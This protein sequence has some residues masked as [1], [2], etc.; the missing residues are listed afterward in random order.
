[1][2]LSNKS[3]GFSLVEVLI[4]LVILSVSLLALAG[5]MVQTTHN[6]S[7]GNHMTEAS[8]VAQDIFERLR[9]RPYNSM[10]CGPSDYVYGSSGQRYKRDCAMVKTTDDTQAQARITVTWSDPTNHEIHFDYN[11]LSFDEWK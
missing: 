1:L 5:L 8:T 3:K 7:F 4:A 10:T 6:N 9:A 2:T 11:I